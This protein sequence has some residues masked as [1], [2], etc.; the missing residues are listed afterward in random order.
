MLGRP[1]YA[2]YE[3]D[4]MDAVK[5]HSF[6]TGRILVEGQYIALRL[7]QKWDC[8]PRPKF[9]VDASQGKLEFRAE[10]IRTPSTSS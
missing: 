9:R 7:D 2:G 10:D 8:K 5:P 6:K 1:A 3:G 4:A